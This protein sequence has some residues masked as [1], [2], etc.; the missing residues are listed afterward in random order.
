MNDLAIFY[1]SRDEHSSDWK[2]DRKIEKLKIKKLENG[3]KAI[4]NG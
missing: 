1:A 4:D 2:A 3:K